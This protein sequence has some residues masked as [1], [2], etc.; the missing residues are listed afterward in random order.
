MYDLVSVGTHWFSF[1][2][3]YGLVGA[4][5]SYENIHIEHDWQIFFSLT[6]FYIVC[7]NGQYHA[8]NKMIFSAE[9]EVYEWDISKHRQP[10]LNIKIIYINTLEPL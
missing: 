1:I 5:I 8:A 2:E 4:T 3:T 9:I 7:V 10:S 6:Q